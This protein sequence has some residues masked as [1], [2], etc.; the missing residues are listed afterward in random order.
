MTNEYMSTAE[1]GNGIAICGTPPAKR[2][3]TVEDELCDD[4]NTGRVVRRFSGSG[5]Y[6]DDFL[7]VDCGFDVGTGHK[8]FEKGWRKKNKTRA[9]EWLA[10]AIDREEFFDTVS[11]LVQEEMGWDEGD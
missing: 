8:P 9:E 4:C 5:W 7:C 10:E 11:G 2:L 3:T 6:A 1:I